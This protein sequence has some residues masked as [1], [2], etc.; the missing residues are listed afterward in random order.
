MS[1]LPSP[2]YTFRRLSDFTWE[3]VKWLPDRKE[4]EVVYTISSISWAKCTCPSFKNP[5]KHQK[6]LDVVKAMNIPPEDLIY[7]AFSEEGD[8]FILE[9]L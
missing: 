4:P 3:A 7:R 1:D 6:L 8:M 2:Y 5:C 9:G